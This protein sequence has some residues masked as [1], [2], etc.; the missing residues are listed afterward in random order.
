MKGLQEGLFTE[1]RCSVS[2]RS[3]SRTCNSI[4]AKSIVLPRVKVQAR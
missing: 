1:R 3:L 2:W 4:A